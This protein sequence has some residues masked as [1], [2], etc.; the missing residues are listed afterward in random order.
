MSQYL[1][2]YVCLSGCLSVLLPACLKRERMLQYLSLYVCH[3]QCHNMS[4]SMSVSEKGECNKSQYVS[5]Y[6]CL[7]LTIMCIP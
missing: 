3:S 5:L 7:S 4:L 1:S 6:V 2:L